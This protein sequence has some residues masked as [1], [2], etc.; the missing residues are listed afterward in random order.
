MLANFTQRNILDQE[1]CFPVGVKSV[2]EQLPTTANGRKRRKALKNGKLNEPFAL[3][4]IPGELAYSVAFK[5]FP[6]SKLGCTFVAIS[7]CLHRLDKMG[8]TKCVRGT[9]PLHQ[10]NPHLDNRV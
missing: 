1:L 8:P 4:A 5:K 9:N 6:S 7:K 3:N 2:R 10:Q